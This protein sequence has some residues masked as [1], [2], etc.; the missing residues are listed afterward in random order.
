MNQAIAWWSLGCAAVPALLFLKNLSLYLPAP[1]PRPGSRPRVSVL[2]PARDE[3]RNIREALEAVLASEDVDFEVVVLDDHSSDA[4]A[5]V[6]EEMASREPRVRLERA[7]ELPPGWCGKQHACWVLAGHATHPLLVFV[8]ADVRL[9]PDSLA[10]FASFIEKSGAELVSGVPHQ[11]TVSWMEKLLIPLIHFVLL[12][13]LPLDRMRKDPGPA[14]GAGCGQLFIAQRDAYRR[15]G[16][17]SAIRA[18]MHDGVTLPRAFRRTGFRTDLFDA[19]PVATCRM[20]HSAGEVWRGLGK[21]AT[22]GLASSR[23]IVPMTVLL[24]SGQV[25]PWLLVIVNP[26]LWAGWFA[27]A[28]TLIPRIASAVRFRQSITGALL[29]PIGVLVL[30]SIQWTAFLG[31]LS[32]RK[33]SWRGRSVQPVRDQCSAPVNT[34]T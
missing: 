6:V 29:H 27:V 19:T 17:H 24:F 14:F 7:P 3:E 34:G 10:R 26:T 32:G 31:K 9:G 18:S 1:A 25:L 2:I 4:T 28:F 15:T 33:S 11:I 22:E 13:F 23:L 8:D 16:G 20:Y 12:G 5:R 21:N 30:L